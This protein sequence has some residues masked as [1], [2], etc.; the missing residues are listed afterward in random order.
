MNKIDMCSF[1]INQLEKELS[2]YS[3]SIS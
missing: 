1:R 3:I 2:H